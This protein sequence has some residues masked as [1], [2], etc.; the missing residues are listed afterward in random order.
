MN[1]LL[2]NQQ[3]IRDILEKAAQINRA[4]NQ[5]A[6]RLCQITAKN[7]D[8]RVPGEAGSSAASLHALPPDLVFA[9]ASHLDSV[10]DTCRL[11]QVTRTAATF[12]L[13]IHCYGCGCSDKA[14]LLS[15]DLSKLW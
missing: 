5:I 11:S 4:S 7:T 8:I 9:I 15:C 3:L 2:T 14:V 6:G 1:A 12:H 13:L 10:K